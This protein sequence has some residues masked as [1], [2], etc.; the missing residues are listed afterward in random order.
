MSENASDGTRIAKCLLA[1]GKRAPWAPLCIKR[2]ASKKAS[3]PEGKGSA[4][5]DAMR[6]VPKVATCKD[7]KETGDR[8]RAAGLCLRA[9]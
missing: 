9:V 6:A 2:R 1:C 4:A 3:E 5:Q 7:N 8:L